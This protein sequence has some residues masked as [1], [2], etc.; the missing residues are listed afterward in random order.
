[1]AA[2]ILIL[3][4][5]ADV[6][7]VSPIRRHIV[8]TVYASG[9]IIPTNEHWISTQISGTLLKKLV[10]E[11]DTI[12]IGQVLYVI[13]DEARQTKLDAAF[14]NYKL[15]SVNLSDSS[16]VLSD[17]KF[18][19][20]A[21]DAKVVNDS[22]NYRRWQN[23]WSQGIGTKS[24]LD[25]AQTQY[26]ISLNENKIAQQQYASK[27]GELTVSKKMAQNV[28]ASTQKEIDN[29]F[30][31]SDQKGIVYETLKNVGESVTPN[32]KLLLIGDCSNRTIKLYI[33]QQD[34]D[35]V[36]IGQKVFVKTDQSPD[37]IFQ[38][39]IIF[40]YPSMNK[41]DQTFCIE[42]KFDRQ[43]PYGFIHTPVEANVVVNEKRNA[44]VVPKEAL[45]GRDSIWIKEKKRY[46]KIAVRTGVSSFDHVEIVS[47]LDE[48]NSVI[49]DWYKL[50]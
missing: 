15:S 7:T 4:S 13:R 18:A 49:I 3:I 46:R 47:G 2:C 16:P 35:K 45:A 31:V 24:N 40:I 43:S 29:S 12:N 36:K 23:L 32:E 10:K 34:I 21:S 8:S 28:L 41:N 20:I 1:M 44:L 14:A 37:T 17:L 38:A 48:N 27:L 33:D 19:L 6:K 26:T 42:A 9:E 11:R 39:S 25:N 50:N 22:I 30:I 5:C